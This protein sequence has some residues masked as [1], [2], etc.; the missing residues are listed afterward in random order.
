MSGM[1]GGGRGGDVVVVFR[2]G[3]L[4]GRLN[5]VS[6]FW[7][8]IARWLSVYRYLCVSTFEAWFPNRQAGKAGTH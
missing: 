7:G 4:S 2:L 8:V 6:P 3:G 5:I 1:G